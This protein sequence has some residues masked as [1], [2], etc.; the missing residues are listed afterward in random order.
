MPRSIF[1]LSDE[2]LNK[3][4]GSVN[5]STP[6]KFN[7]DMLFKLIQLLAILAA[8]IWT[9]YTYVTY[10]K[11]QQQLSLQ[12]QQISKE[13]DELTLEQNK[14]LADTRRDSEEVSLKQQE[15]D[16]AQKNLLADT[17]KNAAETSL[18]QQKFTLA[19]NTLLAGTQRDLARTSLEQQKFTLR[20]QQLISDSEASKSKSEAAIK[21]AQAQAVA[22]ESI[23]IDVKGTLEKIKINESELSEY[24]LKLSLTAQNLSDNEIEISQAWVSMFLGDFKKA[25][26][27][28]SVVKINNPNT[29]GAIEWQQIGDTVVYLS[30]RAVYESS[31]RGK[32]LFPC[33]QASFL[34][35]HL[36]GGFAV[37]TLK[38][39][40]AMSSNMEFRIISHK[41]KWV[42]YTVVISHGK[43]LNETTIMQYSVNNYLPLSEI[44]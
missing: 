30:K 11:G 8:G 14:L 42:G 37:G 27:V 15:F 10:Q 5:K 35:E 33:L 28:Q 41:S 22:Q 26:N 19:Q 44:Q 13:Q 7:L 17:Q 9:I 24:K 31:G 38:R 4:T 3:L 16:L 6:S 40:M 18:N 39:L 21:E 25:D 2:Q 43:C 12:Q 20:Q 1:R 34:S 29:D 36:V 23:K 32:N